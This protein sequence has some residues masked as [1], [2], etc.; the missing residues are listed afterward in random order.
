MELV[1]GEVCRDL[2]GQGFCR[3]FSA[4][5]TLRKGVEQFL[6]SVDNAKNE[7]ILVLGSVNTMR[8]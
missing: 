8:R 1:R 5:L 6:V 4:L 2:L 3:E 7:W